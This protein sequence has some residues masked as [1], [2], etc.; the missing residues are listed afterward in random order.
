VQK[1]KADGGSGRRGEEVAAIE[2]HS[3]LFR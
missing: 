2:L 3:T 1:A